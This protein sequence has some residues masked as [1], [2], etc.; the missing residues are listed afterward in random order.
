MTLMS[1]VAEDLT[2]VMREKAALNRA[3]TPN[4]E[5]REFIEANL[6]TLR[7]IKD[8]FT[9]E[10]TSGKTRKETLT[11]AEAMNVMKR[12][13][14]KL[15]GNAQEFRSLGKEDR[16]VR[17]ER[18]ARIVEGYLPETLDEDATRSLVTKIV[19]DKNLA[20]TGGKGIGQVMGALK[21]RDDVDKALVSKIAKEL[22]A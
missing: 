22:V 11:D 17:E 2:L 18:E 21:D 6:S 10:M 7:A 8:A 12:M 3:E 1:D 19:E 20:G 9:T 16:A 4:E 13:A 14:K 15:R 5:I